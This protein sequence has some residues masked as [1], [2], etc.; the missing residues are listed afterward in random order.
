VDNPPTGSPLTIYNATGVALLTV[1]TD[2]HVG[3]GITNPDTTLHI[4]GSLKMVDGNQAAGKVLTSDANGVGFWQNFAAISADTSSIIADSDR[5]TKIQ[6]EE[7]ADEDIIR[8]YTGGTEYFRMQDGRLDIQNTGR[9]VFIGED[10]GLVDD[11]T[12]NYNVN[13]GY[14]SGE[15]NVGGIRNTGIGAYSLY[16]NVGGTKNTAIGAGGSGLNTSGSSNVAL[17]SNALYDN[18]TGN[19]NVA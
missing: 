6:V 11:R 7:N 18:E 10:A 8:F 17:G 13:I 9:S 19:Y 14:K 4:V 12:N 16:N 15:A 1:D 3:I 2:G 5:D